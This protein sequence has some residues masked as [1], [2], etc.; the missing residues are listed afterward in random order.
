MSNIPKSKNYI[1]QND[2]IEMNKPFKLLGLKWDIKRDRFILALLPFKVNS[3]LTK[4]TVLNH[5]TSQYDPLG[6]MAPILIFGEI[7]FQKLFCKK[8][9]L[10]EEM[11]TVLANGWKKIC[12]EWASISCIHIQ[13]MVPITDFKQTELHVFTDASE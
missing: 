7:F 8:L 1:P 12:L 10:D 2:L 13:R 9:G 6:Y 3:P 4:R 11:H 5:L